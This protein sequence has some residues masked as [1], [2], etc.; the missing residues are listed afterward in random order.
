MSGYIRHATAFSWMLSTACSFV[1]GFGSETRVE[2][3]LSVWL[4]SGY[5][6]IFVLLSIVISRSHLYWSATLH[7]SV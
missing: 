4:I 5:G 7:A 2:I 6:H 1:G 3:R